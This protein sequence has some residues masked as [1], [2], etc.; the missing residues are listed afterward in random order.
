ML[1][2]FSDSA[3]VLK[4]ALHQ[5]TCLNFSLC[6]LFLDDWIAAIKEKLLV[7]TSRPQLNLYFASPVLQSIF[8]M[9]HIYLPVAPRHFPHAISYVLLELPFINVS[10]GP[11]VNSVSVPLVFLV[12][13]LKLLPIA[14]Y[15]TT[16][17]PSLT[18]LELSE[19]FLVTLP[20]VMPASLRFILNVVTS[21]DISVTEI[22]KSFPFFYETH[23]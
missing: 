8:P 17:A 23:L 21:I 12:F 20:K 19:I 5:A 2:E 16:V 14:T 7:K 4:F 6:E 15:P 11:F 18:L 10:I 3:L 13:A 9:S 1:A 22:L